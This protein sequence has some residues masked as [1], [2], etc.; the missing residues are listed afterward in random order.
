MP[1]NVDFIAETSEDRFTTASIQRSM[2]TRCK[3]PPTRDLMY[4][5][6]L[7][8]CHTDGVSAVPDG[9]S[10]FRSDHSNGSC[11]YKHRDLSVEF[12]HSVGSGFLSW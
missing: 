10:V 3:N 1:H 11:I 9:R 6:I 12:H 2:L 4:V 5:S 8:V 7:C